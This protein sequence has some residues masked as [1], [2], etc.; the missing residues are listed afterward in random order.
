MELVKDGK[1]ID[2]KK[3]TTFGE[4]WIALFAWPSTPLYLHILVSHYNDLLSNFGD[5]S[6]FS[7]QS[8]ENYHCKQKAVLKQATSHNGGKKY[9]NSY[10]QLLLYDYRVKFLFQTLNKS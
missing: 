3:L 2:K 9:Q 7:Q 4:K 1:A 5:L 6:D 10:M 8:T